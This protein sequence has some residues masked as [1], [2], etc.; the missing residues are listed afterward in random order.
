[1][2]PE[3][4]TAGE[5]RTLTLVLTADDAHGADR[6]LLAFHPGLSPIVVHLPAARP[7]HRWRLVLESATGLADPASPTV[8]D[9]PVLTLAPRSV[10]L[11]AET[12]AEGVAA[13]PTSPHTTA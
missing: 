8:V 6:V 10:T 5:V 11:L 1:M 9:T 2:T 13:E 3:D 12:H 7:G 4:W